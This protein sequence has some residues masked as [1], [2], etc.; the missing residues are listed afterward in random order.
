M[1]DATSGG[2]SL[3]ARVKQAFLLTQIVVIGCAVTIAS[4]CSND[5]DSD[6]LSGSTAASNQATPQTH[7]EAMLTAQEAADLAVKAGEKAA[8]EAIARA[9]AQMAQQSAQTTVEPVNGSIGSRDYCS[10]LAVIAREA[11]KLR[12]QGIPM[13]LVTENVSQGL[14]HDP[15]RQRMGIGTVI[16]IYG[17]SSLSTEEQ[18]YQAAFDGCSR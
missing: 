3:Y 10:K 9:D 7:A 12:E 5:S 15:M 13:S 11:F 1:S 6:R 18:A 2:N 16:A 17:D 4:G 14:A 8:E